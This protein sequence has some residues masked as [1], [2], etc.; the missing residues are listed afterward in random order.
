MREGREHD[1]A[2]HS[3]R[4]GR[5]ARVFTD[6]MDSLRTAVKR[7][8]ED[9]KVSFFMRFIAPELGWVDYGHEI[10]CVSAQGEI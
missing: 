7:E 9:T 3:I 4:V 5:K 2:W 6:G 8:G 10:P 1:M